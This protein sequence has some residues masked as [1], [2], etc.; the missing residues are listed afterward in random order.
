M[1]PARFGKPIVFVTGLL[2]GAVGSLSVV[3]VL[4]SDVSRPDVTEPTPSTSPVPASPIPSQAPS[5][6]PSPTETAKLTNRDRLRMDGIGSI[7]VGMTVDQ[8]EQ[9]AEIKLRVDKEFTEACRYAFPVQG[10][11]NLAFMSSYGKIVRVD[12]S[13]DSRIK[14]VSGIGVGD[15]EA[16]V[17]RVY[18]DRIKREPHP[19]LHETGSYLVYRP[20][21]ER[22]L[23][24]IFET[25]GKKVISF[26]SGVAEFVR[27]T[28][29]CA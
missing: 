11:R 13:P 29:G 24:L 7:R 23:L 5:E 28:E 15:T 20:A 3:Y 26:R 17:L 25:D 6:S 10:P 19:Y 16:D 4:R 14:T 22:T 21:G 18:G 12:V 27:A 8:A 2:V 1:L 9:A